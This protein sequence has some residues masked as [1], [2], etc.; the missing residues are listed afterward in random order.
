M[1]S[2]EPLY[3]RIF[4]NQIGTILVLAYGGIAGMVLLDDASKILNNAGWW[5]GGL[6][7]IMI[8][9]LWIVSHQHTGMSRLIT[10][11]ERRLKDLETA[12]EESLLAAAA[13]PPAPVVDPQAGPRSRLETMRSYLSA[14]DLLIE[15]RPPASY[16]STPEKLQWASDADELQKKIH[17]FVHQC[18]DMPPEGRIR[19]K[20][21]KPVPEDPQLQQEEMWT[22]GLREL[23]TFR[24][25]FHE[26]ME[27]YREHHKLAEAGNQT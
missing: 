27:L 7:L 23:R 8:V 21:P 9:C 1:S 6:F 2:Q 16:R 4:S 13:P 20:H 24:R 10:D 3:K 14:V 19:M 5:L 26:A 22:S 17:F 11:H 15:V 18:P 25:G 12:G